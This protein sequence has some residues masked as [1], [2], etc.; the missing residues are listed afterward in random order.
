MNQAE[1][2]AALLR[3][4]A[5]PQELFK[6]ASPE[7]V[8]L[9][10]PSDFSEGFAFVN[11]EDLCAC[12]LKDN[13]S[14]CSDQSHFLM[15]LTAQEAICLK[16]KNYGLH[17]GALVTFE[18]LP[19]F[20]NVNN[21]FSN[22]L[23]GVATMFSPQETQKVL[24][25][26]SNATQLG[27]YMV[28]TAPK[29]SDWSLPFV[30]SFHGIKQWDTCKYSPHRLKTLGA[31]I[32]ATSKDATD[33]LQ[34]LLKD[35]DHGTDVETVQRLS[36][37]HER[38]SA[39]TMALWKEWNAFSQDVCNRGL[40]EKTSDE[41]VSKF[42]D[43][44]ADIVLLENRF[45]DQN[46]RFAKKL[47]EAARARAKS[48]DVRVRELGKA[49]VALQAQAKKM[50]GDGFSQ[51]RLQTQELQSLA[52]H[53]KKLRRQFRTVR[54]D[55]KKTE[56]AILK[57][58]RNRVALAEIQAK[59]LGLRQEESDARAR[60]SQTTEGLLA[61]RLEDAFGEISDLGHKL[62]TLED[63]MRASKAKLR[64]T[65]DNQSFTQINASLEKNER[66]RTEVQTRL[67]K[68]TGILHDIETAMYNF[69]M[70]LSKFLFFAAAAFFIGTLRQPLLK[71]AKNVSRTSDAE[72]TMDSLGPV[73][74]GKGKG[75]GHPEVGPNDAPA[76]SRSPSDTSTS[77][78]RSRSRS[79]SP[80][81]QSSSSVASI[82][83]VA[84]APALPSKPSPQQDRGVILYKS[85][86]SDAPSDEAK[87]ALK[88][89]LP[90]LE[91]AIASLLTRT[92]SVVP[93]RGV[94]AAYDDAVA[95]LLGDKI[96]KIQE[97]RY[98]AG[99]V[100]LYRTNRGGKSSVI[101]PAPAFPTK[102]T[103]SHNG[104]A[105][106]LL[107][108]FKTGAGLDSRLQTHFDKYAKPDVYSYPKDTKV[109]AQSIPVQCNRFE[110]APE[111]K[112]VPLPQEI[113]R[114][115]RDVFAAFLEEKRNEK[116]AQNVPKREVAAGKIETTKSKGSK[117]G[118]Q[119][120][121]EKRD[122][123][124]KAIL[125]MKMESVFLDEKQQTQL[126]TAVKKVCLYSGSAA[127]D[128]ASAL[129]LL[130]K[131]GPKNPH[132]YFRE[133]LRVLG[134]PLLGNSFD[135]EGPTQS[136]IEISAKE[137]DLFTQSEELCHSWSSIFNLLSGEKNKIPRF[138]PEALLATPDAVKE[139][140]L[141]SLEDASLALKA[142]DKR[143]TALEENTNAA[144]ADLRRCGKTVAQALAL[145]EVLPQVDLYSKHHG[146]P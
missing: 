61:L 81:R 19:V 43:A 89:M 142:F 114:M 88:E 47:L 130:Q 18:G 85:L 102:M 107:Q 118:S 54:S 96:D 108:R 45:V 16:S 15:R 62:R 27:E 120:S 58:P 138:T 21:L 105:R 17:R 64:V 127:E 65:K 70:E 110:R 125:S 84:A 51:D 8:R 143:V 30:K 23:T 99:E 146:A 71:Y 135:A 121:Q 103:T 39:T 93:L 109:D 131:Y 1:I 36:T 91:E 14:D 6:R 13:V 115:V 73:A 41:I 11:Q 2:V 126:N 79:S 10:A 44:I 112:L 25:P 28:A 78:P 95:F 133:L 20:V 53:L 32:A 82:S 31:E 38:L 3:S 100:L 52:G 46:M 35:I 104:D 63:E 123:R 87:A 124:G 67:S 26:T 29:R 76:R 22:I 132:S 56:A 139:K 106:K 50:L 60:L 119:E 97:D 117:Q 4:R 134:I 5:L 68:K 92:C 116:K 72:T 141:N 69:D 48:G 75:K 57:A 94:A 40:D 137:K 49:Y 55:M 83:D 111:E 77:S 80:N 101:G 74:K 59:L 144:P 128:V 98:H 66:E 33:A 122:K 12:G 42:T 136:Y 34:L 90:V 37:A 129:K 113:A 145:L 7:N 24:Q 140:E 86:L 9:I